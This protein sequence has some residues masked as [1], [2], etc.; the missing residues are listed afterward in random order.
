MSVTT[1]PRVDR[2]R[3]DLPPELA[4]VGAA[5]LFGATF[6]VVKDAVAEAEPL[7]FLAVRFG[8][9]ALVLW[10]LAR[11]RRA[12]PGEWRAGTA[13]GAALGLGYLLQTAGLQHTESSTSAF[14][15]YLLVVI[16]PL[17][18]ALVLRRRPH[19]FT[20]AGVV[21]AVA[22]LALLTG[23]AGV[24][25][26]RGEALTLACAVGFAAHIVVLA[27]VAPHHDVVRLTA[28]QMV[29]VGGACLVPGAI[30]GGY[31]F[32][33]GPWAAA[34]GLGVAATAL[35]FLLQVWG[36]RQVGASRTA[37]ILLLEPIA[38]AV[39][40]ALAGER[41]GIGGWAGAAL[42]LVAIVVAEVAPMRRAADRR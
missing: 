40:G 28:I 12:V 42:I 8:V 6:L 26:G 41:L 33:A 18:S 34:V 31:G 30:W 38:A 25:F 7:P 37:L 36:Q 1:P 23:G 16:V 22:G 4:V 3:P 13:A 19:R 14:I 21:L 2:S 20:V 27:R 11:R 15:T 32:G 9:A 24:G 29:V 10:P 39:L 5:L 17:L 35:A